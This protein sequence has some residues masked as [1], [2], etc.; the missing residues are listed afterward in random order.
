LRTGYR[1][2]QIYERLNDTQIDRLFDVV[3]ENGID[4]ALC[5]AE[6]L[7]FDWHGGVIARLLGFKALSQILGITFFR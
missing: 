5:E 7:S 2:R 6:D 3:K 1:A 4:R